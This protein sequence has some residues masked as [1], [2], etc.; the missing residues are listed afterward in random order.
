MTF[1]YPFQT[2]LT[3]LDPM[4]F[5]INDFNRDSILDVV[6]VNLG[7]DTFS[8]LLGNGNGTFQASINYSTGKE[9]SPWG[10][11]TADFN[12]DTLLDL[13][14]HLLIYQNTSNTR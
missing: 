11:T 12:N 9:T 5:V 6:V 4:S 10:I 2:Y 8:V 13:G 7:D 3:G 14:K 1:K